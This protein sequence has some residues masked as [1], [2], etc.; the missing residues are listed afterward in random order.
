MSMKELSD[1]LINNI[2]ATVTSMDNYCQAM[3]SEFGPTKEACANCK[4]RGVHLGDTCNLVNMRE[5][6]TTFRKIK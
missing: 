6:L 4:F 3:L 2:M 5:Q 1:E